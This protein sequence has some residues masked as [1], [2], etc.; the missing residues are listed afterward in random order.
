MVA[1]RV[2]GNISSPSRAPSPKKDPEGREG[3][4]VGKERR[5]KR[6]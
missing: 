3:E 5:E 2:Y 1:I 6:W 4:G